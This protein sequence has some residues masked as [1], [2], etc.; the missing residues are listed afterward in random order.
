VYVSIYN[1]CPL[2]QGDM[3]KK[4]SALF[5]SCKGKKKMI[6]KVQW[7]EEGL[8]YY[9]HAERKYRE[10]YKSQ[11]MDIIYR[12]WE[13]WLLLVSDR[14]NK[15]FLSVDGS[16]SKT[17]HSIMGTWIRNDKEDDCSKGGGLTY[18]SDD[19]ENGDDEK[20]YYSDTGTGTNISRWA[21][22][23]PHPSPNQSSPDKSV[24]TGDKAK[25]EESSPTSHNSTAEKEESDM[26]LD[27]VTAAGK[28]KKSDTG[29]RRKRKDTT[30]TNSPASRTRARG[31]LKGSKLF[32]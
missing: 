27:D 18:D 26:G 1:S 21:K 28:R 14:R 23:P 11:L 9:K 13:Q 31:K 20:G 2:L 7:N 8:K 10:L 16:S 15:A 22:Q 25:M 30:L 32:E 5:T 19:E 17:F 29:K 3:N 24:D 6:G 4:A 12:G